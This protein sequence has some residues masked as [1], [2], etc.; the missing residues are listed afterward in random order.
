MGF[1]CLQGLFFKR[2]QPWLWLLAALL[3]PCCALAEISLN[4]MR[5]HHY[6]TSDSDNSV[7]GIGAIK[8]ILQDANGFMW[9]AGEFGLARFDSYQ[10]KFFYY[11]DADP[12][13]L[14][15]N[16]VTALVL[17]KNGI[18]WVGTGNG[19]NRYN[20]QTEQFDRFLADPNLSPHLSGN[21]VYALA[22]D[23]ENRLYIGTDKGLNRLN[24]ARTQ[25]D[26]FQHAQNQPTSLS[27]N[28][29][30]ALL[31]D[32]QQRLWVGT[33]GAGLNRYNP[34][35]QD[36][37]R[38]PTSDTALRLSSTDIESLLQDALGQIWVGTSSGG[39]NCISAD[40]KTLKRYLAQPD[41]PRSLGS[42]DI[43]NLYE[44]RA[45]R[46]WVSTDHGGLALYHPKTDDFE[47][48]KHNPYDSN[49]LRSNQVRNV[50]EDHNGNLW[51]GSFPDGINFYD[52]NKARFNL[53]FQQTKVPKGLP[54]NGIL[55]LL[56][57]SKGWIWAGTEGGLWGYNPL[58]KEAVSYT[59]A[60][61]KPNALQFSAVSSLAEAP[62]GDLWVGTWS[63]GLH[64][65]NKKTGEFKHYPADTGQPGGLASPY[66]WQLRYDKTQT[67]WIS[68]VDRGGFARYLPETDTFETFAHNPNDANSLSSDH[69]MALMPDSAGNIW[70]GTLNGLNK[71]NPATKTFTHYKHDPKNRNS[72][73][74]DY[75]LAIYEDRQGQIW[76]GT[77]AAGVSLFNPKTQQ[78]RHIKMKDGLPSN[79]V[80]SLLEDAQGIMWIG[81]LNGVASYNPLTQHIRSY[82]KS[83]GFAGNSINR[84]AM[85]LDKKGLVWVGSTGGLT[86]F[87]PKELNRPRPAPSVV[88]TQLRI[89]NK[90]QIPAASGSRLTKSLLHTQDL[91]LN[92][93]DVMFAIDFTA[94]NF[95]T[96]DRTQFAYKLAGFDKN[97]NEVGKEH[98]ATY[99]NIPAGHYLFQVKAANSDG[100]WSEASASLAIT[101][102][103]P[104]WASGWAYGVYAVCLLIVVYLRYQYVQLQKTSKQYQLLS[105]RDPLTGIS[106]RAG[107]QPIIQGLFINEEMKQG[108]CLLVFDIDHFK[109]IND[110][111]GHAAG[112]KILIEVAQV[113]AASVRAADHLAR[114]GGEEFILLCPS[115]ALES[116][117]W[118]AQKIRHTLSHHAFTL[119]NTT[120][121][122]TISLGVAACRAEDTF[123]TLFKRADEALYRAKHSG[124]NCVVLELGL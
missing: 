52:V 19:L 21:T 98:A 91:T 58:K 80:A 4:A 105:T 68:F 94:L 88:L 43:R 59:A 120:L 12:H 2:I 108:L 31:I 69:V 99:T 35:T 90:V 40:L 60:P 53:F 81:T 1:K 96:S 85:L 14:S 124:R 82:R 113:V 46:L 22:V 101:I 47:T 89:A 62:D 106:N 13:S 44:D 3:T 17:D 103:P 104:F 79:S 119:D 121:S 29:V 78:F 5:F 116:A 72:L 65:F 23:A 41:N 84:N 73:P 49:S 97:W 36:F 25:V 114:W 67:L 7:Q 93:K 66:V 34:S 117:R 33:T 27:G 42:N 56:E 18:L 92:Y 95:N 83:D 15:A 70:L 86:Q 11:D 100:T 38:W 37:T 10:F 9:F 63:G 75:V 61:Q 74:S 123:E 26:I 109:Q 8:S 24:A 16:F 45:K 110:R 118:L 32:A 51:I 122:V 30:R 71:F 102:T 107:M 6:L 115:T 20:A 87:N 77:Q 112:D 57:D 111:F 55:S 39:L 54:S 28:T 64:K 76:I 50:F 48:L